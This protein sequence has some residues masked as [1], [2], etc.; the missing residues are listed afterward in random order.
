MA[1]DLTAKLSKCEK[2]YWEKIILFVLRKSLPF[3]AYFNPGGSDNVFTVTPERGELLPEDE[4]GTLIK[5]SFVPFTY[6]KIYQ[7]EL[8]ISVNFIYN[9]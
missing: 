7:K 2:I 3:E 6:G 8:I 1:L 9:F 5:I 4:D